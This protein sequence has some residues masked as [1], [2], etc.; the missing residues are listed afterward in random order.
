MTATEADIVS[1]IKP[2]HFVWFAPTVD[3]YGFR[4]AV[5][6]EPWIANPNTFNYDLARD[7]VTVVYADG[8]VHDHIRYGGHEVWLFGD[9]PM[10]EE[11]K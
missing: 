3:E 5:T 7:W 6:V 9:R 2:G 1:E 11:A 10:F 8:H 4:E